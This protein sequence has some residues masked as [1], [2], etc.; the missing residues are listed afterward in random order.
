MKNDCTKWKDALLEAALTGIGEE[1]LEEHVLDCANC[2]EQL[3]AL[4]VRREQLDRLL[5]LVAQGAQ[6]SPGFRARLLA[7]AWSGSE[8]KP[9]RWR[10]WGLCG[11]MAMTVATLIVGLKLHRRVIRTVPENELAA[12][13]KLAEWRAPSDVLLETPGLTILRTMPRL[14][15]SY[16]HVPRKTDQEE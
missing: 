9:G 13:E 2:A 10:V 3:A 15:D 7:T 12:A 4:R 16:L 1:S 8:A 14:G 5:P 11:A 6:P